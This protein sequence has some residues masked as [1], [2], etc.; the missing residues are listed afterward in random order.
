[1]FKWFLNLSQPFHFKCFDASFNLFLWKLTFQTHML[2]LVH[3]WPVSTV[4]VETQ[5]LNS[6]IGHTDLVEYRG[7]FLYFMPTVLYACWRDLWGY[8]WKHNCI[9]ATSHVY[10]FLSG[11]HLWLLLVAG[12][13][14]ECLSRQEA[15]RSVWNKWFQWWCAL[16]SA[17]C[18]TV[19]CQLY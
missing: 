17:H 2:R 7:R 15:M 8:D 12:L 19:I 16:R 6:W 3:Q 14:E 10:L 18:V 13:E 1:M 5:L 11:V 4:E 9:L